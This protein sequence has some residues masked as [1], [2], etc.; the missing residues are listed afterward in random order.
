M[1][2]ALEDVGCFTLT[3]LTQ[4]FISFS[5]ICLFLSFL[6]GVGETPAIVEKEDDEEY[7]DE[8]GPSMSIEKNQTQSAVDI[9]AQFVY[10]RLKPKLVTDLVLISLVS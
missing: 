4:I 2:I 6:K 7:D 9:T 3:L 10:E 5:P 1:L 8:A